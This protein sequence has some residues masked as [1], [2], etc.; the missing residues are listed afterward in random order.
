M[1]HHI[2]M[3]GPHAIY[4]SAASSVTVAWHGQ[5]INIANLLF[6]YSQRWPAATSSLGDMARKPAKEEKMV[7]PTHAVHTSRLTGVMSA[8]AAPLP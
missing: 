8:A 6:A 1:A 2:E 5:R 3:G 7:A 4:V